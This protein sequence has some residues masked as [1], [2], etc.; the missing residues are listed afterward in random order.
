MKHS[1]SLAILFCLLSFTSFSQANLLQSGPMVGYSE[2]KE[3]MLWVQTTDS[4]DVRIE[5][6]SGANRKS[7]ASYS[8]K[9]SEGF[10]AHLLADEVE[11]GKTYNY[12]LFINE[13][14]VDL[15]YTLKFKT[16]SL[17]QY[18]SD[19][20]SFRFATGSCSYVNDAAED[21]PGTGY[22]GDHYIYRSIAE[23][24][25]DFMM[26]LGDNLYF[27]EPDF[28][29]WT[30]MMHRYTNAR[31]EEN[32]QRLLGSVHHY[33]TWDDHDFGPNDSD[34]SYSKKEKTTQA[35]KLF[36]ANNGYG[37]TGNGGIT[38]FFKWADCDFFLLDNRTFRSPND[39]KTGERTM[40]GK[41]QFEWLIDAL[42]ASS[43]PFKFVCVGGQVVNDAKVW[44]TYANL[45][46]EERQEILDAI[47]TEQVPGV[48]FLT[49]DRHHTELSMY[50][51]DGA[52]FPIYD[53]TV[54]PLTSKA[55]PIK[56]EQNSYRVSG[57]G[58]NERNFAVLDVAGANKARTVKITVFDAF[59]TEKWSKTIGSD[60]SLTD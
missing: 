10:T 28:Y 25:P 1:I 55:Y 11:P 19:P 16:Q 49:G 39:R 26:W 58:Y 54:S 56:D 53:L 4:A 41:D 48:I 23:K 51:P 59:G 14:Q 42:V 20:P 34:R 22:G 9:K 43:A 15:P 36:W 60:Y 57:T 46:P 2:M 38:G 50:Q 35:F 32:L 13:K 44:E 27:R 37:V 18:R 7:T 12:A 47:V 45:F 31:S 5:Y 6:W 29:S 3:V 52:N 24:D 17:W 21:R 30:G 33:A 8:T 40:L